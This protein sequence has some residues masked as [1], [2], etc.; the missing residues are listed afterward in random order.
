[1]SGNILSFIIAIV[2]AF[3]SLFPNLPISDFMKK[4]YHPESKVEV[5]QLAPNPNGLIES[6]V[7]KTVNN[8]IIVID[9]GTDGEGMNDPSYLPAAIRAILRL[10]EN[11]YFEIEAWFISHA[12]SDHFFE[13]AKMLRDYD[14]KSNYRINNF[15][16]NFPD[17]GVE[18]NSVSEN[19]AEPEAFQVLKDGFENYFRR[20]NQNET[21]DSINGRYI[22][23]E[24]V[25]SGLS[26]NIDAVE[27][28]VLQNWSKDDLII[29][30]TSVVYRLK[31]QNHS[32]LFLGDTYTDSEKR[33]L[34]KYGA[35]ALKSE[36]VQMAHHGQ[37]GASKDFYDAIDCRN[38]IRLWPTP[39]WVWNTDSS[40]VYAVYQTREWLGLPADPDEFIS[41]G[42][43]ETGKDYVA[44]IYKKYPTKPSKKSSW[45]RDILDEQLAA[46]F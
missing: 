25:E 14:E 42:L 15:Y 7:I 16:F 34:E 44:G 20:T 27:I 10:H 9:G 39:A 45:T 5:Y 4:Y 26:F 8:K 41:Q 31:Y 23:D 37:N 6:Y 22:T 36:Y 33:L 38:S 43:N 13:L 35:D 2:T 18:W 32:I 29:N 24:A 28:D 21:Y 3:Y 1:M 30:S 19:D 40:S 46:R 12:H 11:E 17:I